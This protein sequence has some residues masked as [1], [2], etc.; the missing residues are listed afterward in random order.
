MSLEVMCELT[1]QMGACTI[2]EGIELPSGERIG[3]IAD[4]DMLAMFN[5]DMYDAVKNINK[6]EG[7]NLPLPNMGSQL[8]A[9]ELVGQDKAGFGRR[10]GRVAQHNGDVVRTLKVGEDAERKERVET[11]ALL[12]AAGL[13][14]WD[15]K[16]LPK[17]D[18]T[19]VDSDDE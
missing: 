4:T 11:L 14:L 8:W 18:E 1:G 2:C 17:N 3:A 16:D 5:V 9:V 10:R 6:N 7:L 13:P 19:D 12:Y 15:D